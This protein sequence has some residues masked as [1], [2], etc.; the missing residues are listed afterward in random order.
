G[1]AVQHR[2]LAAFLVIE[3]QLERDPRAAG[4][5]RMRRIWAVSDQIARIRGGQCG[6]LK[7]VLASLYTRRF[8]AQ[9][10]RLIIDARKGP[11]RGTPDDACTR[12]RAWLPRRR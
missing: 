6:S 2:I 5:A 12:H 9:A 1:I 8:T 7:F 4:P 10:S 11:L 3:H